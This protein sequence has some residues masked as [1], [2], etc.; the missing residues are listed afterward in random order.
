MAL[1]IR[2]HPNKFISSWSS[3]SRF[4]DKTMLHLH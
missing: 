2:T 3:Q 4:S 1:A